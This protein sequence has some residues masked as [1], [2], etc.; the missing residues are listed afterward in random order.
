MQTRRTW[1]LYRVGL[2]FAGRGI[3]ISLCIKDPTKFNAIGCLRD[4]Q[5]K[6]LHILLEPRDIASL[7]TSWSPTP[8]PSN[9]RPALWTGIR[10]GCGPLLPYRHLGAA[11]GR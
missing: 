8:V 11:S 4:G 9:L 10:R 6:S 3:S 2:I 5:I 1:L 7:S